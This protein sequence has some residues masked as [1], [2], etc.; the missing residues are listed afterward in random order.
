MSD[1]L[2]SIK[3]K[4][5]TWFEM[6]RESN[7]DSGKEI[8]I[9][10]T[11]TTDLYYSI[12]DI[13]PEQDNIDYKIFR[14]GDT[15]QFTD[16]DI[17]IWIFSPQ[18]DGLVNVGLFISTVESLLGILISEIRELNRNTLEHSELSIDQFKLLNARFEEMAN[19]YINEEDIK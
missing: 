16:G 14:R 11:G 2:P 7:I 5:E 3:L 12:S 9:Q 4:S 13:Q 17:S 10:N 1:T 15:V 19:T 18:A 8:E 6:Y